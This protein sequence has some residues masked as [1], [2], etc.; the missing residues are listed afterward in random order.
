MR[1][2]PGVRQLLFVLSLLSLLGLRVIGYGLWVMEFTGWRSNVCR[3]DAGAPLKE[4][5]FYRRRFQNFLY[6]CSR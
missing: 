2:A 6:L 4:N 3:R 5:C 1:C